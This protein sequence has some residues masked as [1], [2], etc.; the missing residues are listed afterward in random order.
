VPKPSLSI[1]IVVLGSSPPQYG[2][3]RG[4]PTR[5][6][7]SVLPPLRPVADLQRFRLHLTPLPTAAP[8]ARGESRRPARRVRHE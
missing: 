3:N 5:C 7:V 8:R 4:R 2:G 1:T 6:A